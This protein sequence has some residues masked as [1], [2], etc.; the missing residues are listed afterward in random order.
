MPNQI[1]DKNLKL[2]IQGPSQVSTLFTN[3]L[4]LLVPT[5]SYS[6]QEAACLRRRNFPVGGRK[7]SSVFPWPHFGTG[8]SPT[9]TSLSSGSS[10]IAH[11]SP[12]PWHSPAPYSCTEAFSS[13]SHFPFSTQWLKTWWETLACGARDDSDKR[14]NVK[15]HPVKNKTEPGTSIVL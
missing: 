11:P 2:E 10:Y 8:F 3:W 4:S 14:T 15:L 9:L 1:W 12:C 5:H 6:S 13:P 7:N